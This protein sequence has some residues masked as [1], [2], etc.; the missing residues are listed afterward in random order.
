[1]MEFCSHSVCWGLRLPHFGQQTTKKRYREECTNTLHY[2]ILG[3][4]LPLRVCVWP[5]QTHHQHHDM[6]PRQEEEE[7]EEEKEQ[8][9]WVKAKVNICSTQRTVRERERERETN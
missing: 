1:M 7:E 5:L 6:S 9:I 8:K 2:W 3:F 4:S